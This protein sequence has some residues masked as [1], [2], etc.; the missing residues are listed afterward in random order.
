VRLPKAS[1]ASSDSVPKSFELHMGRL[2]QPA[3]L[4]D[5]V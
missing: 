1:T 5:V 2:G 3:H 4:G